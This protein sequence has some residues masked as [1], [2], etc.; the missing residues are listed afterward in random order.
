MAARQ[1]EARS[2]SITASPTMVGAVTTLIVVVAVFLAYNANSGLPF[3][4][5]YRV[6]VE[7]P[8]AARLTDN[9]E[10]RIGGNRV[11][12]VESIEAIRAD[13]ATATAA[14]AGGDRRRPRP[15]ASVARL[16]LKLDRTA[17]P[18]PKDSI[19]RVR[20]RSTF[21]LKYLEIIRGTGKDAPEG[22]TFNGLDDSGSCALPV[23]PPTLPRLDPGDAKERLLPAADRV[24]RDRQHL[25]HEDPDGRAHQPRSASATPSPAAAP[26]STTRS[27]ASSRCSAGWGR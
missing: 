12:V 15:A 25:R 1:P 19:F 5:V 8:D 3:V 7:V 14:S 18:L 20:Y 27:T 6:S 11:G 26:R 23:D 17:G 21:G 22:Y 16:N 9:N 24:R 4:P 13:D 10:V 2:G